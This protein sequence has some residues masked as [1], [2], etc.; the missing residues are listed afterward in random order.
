M[1]VTTRLAA[2]AAACIVALPLCAQ[3]GTPVRRVERNKVHSPAI[4]GN[5]EGNT[6][7]R[8]VL[9]Y[10]PPSYDASGGRG[11][12]HGRGC[13]DRD[14]RGRGESADLHEGS[15]DAHGRVVAEPLEAA[16]VF[17]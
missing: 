3:T 14:A 13:E 6:A 7:D 4:E 11:R 15:I 16:L 12:R 10:L 8:D 5:L 1:K 9:V 2:A 17:E